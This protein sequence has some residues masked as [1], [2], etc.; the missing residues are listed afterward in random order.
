RWNS[1]NPDGSI[2]STSMNSL[3]HYAYGS[4]VEWMYRDM[5]GLNPSAGDDDVTGFRHARIA[6]KPD[7]SLQWARARYHSAAGCYES[8]WRIDE[9]GR[10]TIEITIPFNA[11]ARVVLPNAQ[12]S[13][14]T[15]NDQ[16]L[17]EGEQIG[18][19]VE[20]TLGAGSYTIVYPFQEK[21]IPVEM[22]APASRST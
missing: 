2:S 22:E 19:D 6:P 14:I 17:H 3:N 7:K 18:D 4:I 15:I 12:L 20:L 1:L 11:F 13:Q 9:A 16:R 5:C 10:L 21:N 8:G